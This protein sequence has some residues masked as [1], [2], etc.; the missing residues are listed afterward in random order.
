M[1]DGP[2]AGDIRSNFTD[3]RLPHTTHTPYLERGRSYHTK[4]PHIS[5]WEIKMK[6]NF[7]SSTSPKPKT[8]TLRLHKQTWRAFL[9]FLRAKIW[10]GEFRNHKYRMTLWPLEHKENVFLLYNHSSPTAKLRK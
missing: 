5:F 3:G 9:F 8:P 10:L 6:N 2:W 1:T 4:L 7:I